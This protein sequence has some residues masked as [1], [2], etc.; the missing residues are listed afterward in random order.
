MPNFDVYTEGSFFF[1]KNQSKIMNE[2]AKKKPL[3]RFTSF[4]FWF[5]TVLIVSIGFLL[6][7]FLQQGRVEIPQLMNRLKTADKYWLSV[8]V[9]LTFVFV[10]LQG[11]MYF[12]SFR[13][14]GEKVSRWQAIGLYLK[15]NFVS[16][17]LPVGSISSMAT[18]T[19][20]IEKKGL[21]PL[22]ISIAS[23][24]YLISG[25][26][27]L[28]IIAIPILFLTAQSQHIDTI[29]YISLLVLTVFLIL[30]IIFISNLKK[31][32]KSYQLFARFLP[33]H[34]AQLDSFLT[35]PIKTPALIG[36]N[37][38]S[39]GL[40]IVG[41]FMLFVSVYAI[42]FDIAWLIPCLAYTIATL[43]LYVAPVA[44]GV[45]AIELSLIYVLTQN[46]LDANAA[47]T[48]T[49][50]SRFFGFWLPLILGG[51]SFINL[52]KLKF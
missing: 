2:P 13:S 29:A 19:Q 3:N 51:L 36:A 15:R 18:F 46:G 42:G 30:G 52:K 8:G 34:V 41:I 33:K 20:S 27:T 50:L 21:T 17:F 1:S 24:I 23:A 10:I 6:Y 37:L 12:W 7:K 31:R 38:A 16:V 39:L 25:I 5:K 45:G 14:V 32:G 43:I 47:L 22:K 9:L 28:W 35:T 44:R 48:V 4:N 11:E 49:L 40:E 26:V